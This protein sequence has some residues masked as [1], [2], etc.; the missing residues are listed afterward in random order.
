MHRFL[1]LSATDTIT[2]TVTVTITITITRVYGSLQAMPHLLEVKV[3]GLSNHNIIG[4]LV[5]HCEA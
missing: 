1:D 2:I 5:I 3:A 4:A